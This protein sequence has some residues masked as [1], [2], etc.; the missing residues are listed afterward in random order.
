MRRG[1]QPRACMVLMKLACRQAVHQIAGLRG[2]FPDDAF[3]RREIAGLPNVME[4]KAR[5]ALGPLQ[6][7]SPHFGARRRTF[8][9]KR[10][11]FAT[12]STEVRLERGG[13]PVAPLWLFA[14]ASRCWRGQSVRPAPVRAASAAHE[15]RN[16]QRVASASAAHGCGTRRRCARAAGERALL[17]SASQPVC[18][19]P[20]ASTTRLRSAA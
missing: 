9:R 14:A 8:R 2:L 12:G 11:R 3:K 20:Q 1:S 10:A 4:L 15:P 17:T 16:R 6:Q 13:A 5:R 19:A 7:R 18:C